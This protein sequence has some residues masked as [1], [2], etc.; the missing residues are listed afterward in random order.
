MWPTRN[1]FEPRLSHP[2][3]PTVRRDPP[4]LISGCHTRVA[5]GSQN[6]GGRVLCLG[7]NDLY[8]FSSREIFHLTQLLPRTVTN[9][10]L[11]HVKLLQH[12]S[13]A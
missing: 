8:D 4:A 7:V 9:T 2:P 11:D 10:N 13:H 1:T 5:G 3:V 12:T 6:S